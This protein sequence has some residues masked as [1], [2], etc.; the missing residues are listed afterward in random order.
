MEPEKNCPE[1]VQQLLA[2][3]DMNDQAQNN[4]DKEIKTDSSD[5]EDE[6]IDI[7]ANCISPHKYFGKRVSFDYHNL[8]KIEKPIFRRNSLFDTIKES[9]TLMAA[10]KKEV[11]SVKFQ[12]KNEEIKVEEQ[13][14]YIIKKEPNDIDKKKKSILKNTCFS[15]HLELEKIFLDKEFFKEIMEKVFKECGDNQD[16]ISEKLPNL[17]HEFSM[18]KCNEG[19]IV[20]LIKVS[21]VYLFDEFIDFLRGLILII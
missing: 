3:L 2:N 1:F 8:K 14:H 15:E 5:D 11:L 16:L 21:I 17:Y 18:A 13:E 4:P 9:P 19:M 20:T 6:T 12:E 7:K 10:K